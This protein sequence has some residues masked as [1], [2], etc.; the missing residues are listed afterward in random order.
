[1]NKEKKTCLGIPVH[2]QR[3][4]RDSDFGLTVRKVEMPP[5]VKDWK[6]ISHNVL[7][8]GLAAWTI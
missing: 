4:N 1:M 6:R 3:G 2:S 8:K 7:H 5:Q